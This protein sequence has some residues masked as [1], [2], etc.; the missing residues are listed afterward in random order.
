VSLATIRDFCS[1]V[2]RPLRPGSLVLPP[3]IPS[4][5]LVGYPP[6]LLLPSGRILLPSPPVPIDLPTTGEEI[7]NQNIFVFLRVPSLA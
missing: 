4:Y 7:G 5:D 1:D 3:W 6:L 2:S